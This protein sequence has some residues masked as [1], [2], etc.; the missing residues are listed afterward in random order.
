MTQKEITINGKT[1]PVAFDLQTMIGFEDITN[2]TSFFEAKFTAIKERI[3][4][5]LAAVISV[6]ENADIKA[7]D[8]MKADKWQTVQEIFK[9]YADI[10]EMA[11]EFFKI[12]EIEKKNDTP[13]SDED[14]KENAAKN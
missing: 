12:P 7:E 3:A 8:L 1:Y 5:I 14:Q 10:M 4:L 11:A 9:A 2:G 13:P 6:D